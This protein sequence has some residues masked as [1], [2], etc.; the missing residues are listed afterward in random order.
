MFPGLDHV[1]RVDRLTFNLDYDLRSVVDHYHST[2]GMTALMIYLEGHCE[3]CPGTP[4]VV[5]FFLDRGYSVLVYAMPLF[6]PNRD[7]RYT[8][9]GSQKH[10]HLFADFEPADSR[11][12]RLFLEPVVLG[13]NYALDTFGYDF[14][15]M[16]G[17][18]GGGWTT[19]LYAGLDTR[20]AASFPVAGTLPFEVRAPRDLGDAEQREERPVYAIANYLSFYMMGASGTGRRQT[21]VLNEADPCCFRA[22]G[23]EEEIRAYEQ[24]VQELLAENGD[25][26]TF[27]VLVV[28]D[29]NGHEISPDALARVANELDI[30]QYRSIL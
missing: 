24:R 30:A 23:K 9:P 25:G 18:S 10:S 4:G 7:S 29:H 12:I 27:A 2:A 22:G 14:V 26:G 5:Q 3:W 8:A 15:A 6:G 16:I 19:T 20:I 21:Q 28:S 17:L 1:A 11:L 13:T